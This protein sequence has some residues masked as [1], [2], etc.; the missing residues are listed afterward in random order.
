MNWKETLVD[1]VI[2]VV[3]VIIALYVVRMLKL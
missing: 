3:G 2:V 1:L